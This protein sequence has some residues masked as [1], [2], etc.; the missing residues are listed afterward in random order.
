MSNDKSITDW[1]SSAYIPTA[2]ETIEWGKLLS[3][4]MSSR[5]ETETDSVNLQ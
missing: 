3:L 4:F 5:K 2:D 1:K